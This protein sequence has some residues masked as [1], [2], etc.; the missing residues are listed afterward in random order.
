MDLSNEI[1]KAL[2]DNDIEL[3]LKLL[4]GNEKTD[5]DNHWIL[6]TISMCMRM[7]GRFPEALEYSERSLKICPTCP[8]TQWQ[9][10]AALEASG[11][12]QEAKNNYI[13]FLE[14]SID[15]MLNDPCSEG[16]DWVQGMIVDCW[17]YIGAC[18]EELSEFSYAYECY[19]KYLQMYST[20]LDSVVPDGCISRAISRVSKKTKLSGHDEGV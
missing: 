8:Y 20:N 1:Q 3:S 2:D 18:S 5:N 16:L 15:E 11:Q 4:L 9:Y 7:V 17:Y 10:A 6:T 12:W 13:K 19:K 14:R